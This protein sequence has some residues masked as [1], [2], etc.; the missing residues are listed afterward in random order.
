MCTLIFFLNTNFN[1]ASV[2]E[3]THYFFN[4]L[5]EVEDNPSR[6]TLHLKYCLTYL[7]RSKTYILQIDIDEYYW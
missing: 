1:N 5:C 7:E 4:S 3:T 2:Y 6:Y